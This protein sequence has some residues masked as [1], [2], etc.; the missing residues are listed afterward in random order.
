MLQNPINSLGLGP[1][2][3]GR[4]LST[5]TPPQKH[6]PSNRAKGIGKPA[7]NL[8]KTT[9]HHENPQKLKEPITKPYR[10]IGFGA[11]NV[12]KPYKFIGF[13][14]VEI[15]KPYKIIGFGAMDVTKPYRFIRVGAMNVA[16][17]YKFIGFG[18]VTTTKP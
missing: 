17:P 9:N 8:R 11:M 15:T 13:G 16:K 12:T 18:A 3:P 5:E 2:M 7:G 1:W 14:A 4:F 6:R 10:F